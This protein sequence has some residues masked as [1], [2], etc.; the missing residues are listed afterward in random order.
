MSR[1]IDTDGLRVTGA[2]NEQLDA[3][4]GP[5]AVTPARAAR[6]TGQR[7]TSAARPGAAAQSAG[8]Q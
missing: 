4:N 7:R 1:Y 3:V 6:C 5:A 8:M 2:A